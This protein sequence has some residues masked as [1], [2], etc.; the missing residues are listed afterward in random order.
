M[1]SGRISGNI[2]ENIFRSYTGTISE[3][4]KIPIFMFL[5]P[6]LIARAPQPGGNMTSLTLNFSRLT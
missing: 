1:L 5:F 2:G 3:T 6:R 4:V